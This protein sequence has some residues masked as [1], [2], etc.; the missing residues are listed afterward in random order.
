MKASMS[1]SRVKRQTLR[2]HVCHPRLLCPGK[3][4]I[5]IHRQYKI[6]HERTKFNHYLTTK[7]ALHKILEGKL[8]PK[9]VSYNHKTQSID[10]I[11]KTNPKEVENTHNNIANNVNF[12]KKELAIT[13]H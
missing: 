6:A 3:F 5:N 12:K 4:I 11:T 13:G 7:P 1:W 2:D 10:D 8:Q 9:E